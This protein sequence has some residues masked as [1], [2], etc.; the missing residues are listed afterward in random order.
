MSKGKVSIFGLG[1]FLLRDVDWARKSRK[2]RNF[3]VFID[4]IK[5]L[6]YLYLRVGGII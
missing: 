1:L 3:K 6:W 4:G 2:S 5:K